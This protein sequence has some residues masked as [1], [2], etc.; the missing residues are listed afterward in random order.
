MI[1]QRSPRSRRSTR[2][3][4]RCRRKCYYGGECSRTANGETCSCDKI[5]CT[6]EYDPVCGNDEYTYPNECVMRHQRCIKQKKITI[7]Y[8]GVCSKYYHL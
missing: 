6:K 1:I 8:R 7:A 2:R 4:R 3:R 5:H